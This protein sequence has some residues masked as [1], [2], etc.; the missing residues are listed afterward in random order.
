[1]NKKERNG[2]GELSNARGQSFTVVLLPVE[3]QKF[4]ILTGKGV[5]LLSTLREDHQEGSAAT[6]ESISTTVSSTKSL[7]ASKIK[8]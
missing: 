1:M 8:Q 2:A 7:T 6:P 4:K 5:S 3:S